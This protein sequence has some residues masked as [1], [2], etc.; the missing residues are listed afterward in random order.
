MIILHNVYLTLL[1][2]TQGSVKL[3]IQNKGKDDALESYRDLYQKNLK[4]TVRS[5]IEVQTKVTKLD[6]ADSM[7]ELEEK[8]DKWHKDIRY[9]RQIGGT[10]VPEEQKATV[11]LQLV[12]ENL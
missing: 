8:L 12:P 7:N 10:M 5:R 4:L 3:R 9:F 6:P 11:I 1:N 2:C